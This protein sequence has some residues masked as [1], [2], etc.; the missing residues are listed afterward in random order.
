M[1]LRVTD[2]ERWSLCHIGWQ[3]LSVIVMEQTRVS[4]DAERHWV[5]DAERHRDGASVTSVA[6]AVVWSSARCTMVIA[7]SSSLS[8]GRRRRR[9]RRRRRSKRSGE[10]QIRETSVNFVMRQGR[11]I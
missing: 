3:T 8:N 1:T 4:S 5:A 6:A 2:A 10:K 9:R 7:S 11:M